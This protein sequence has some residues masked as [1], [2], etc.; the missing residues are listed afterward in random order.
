[1]MLHFGAVAWD[2]SRGERATMEHAIQNFFHAES[3][4][5]G[6]GKTCDF[7]LAIARTQNRGELTITVTPW[8]FIS[9][10]TMRLNLS[11]IFSR[12]FGKGWRWRRCSAPTFSPCSRAIVTASWIGP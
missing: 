4:P 2:V 9:T 6:L 5:V 12:P 7:R 10:V 3:E 1:M 8:S 11:K